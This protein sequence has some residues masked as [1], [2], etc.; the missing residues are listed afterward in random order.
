MSVVTPDT[1]EE[2]VAVDIHELLAEE[3]MEFI[4]GNVQELTLVTLE[5]HLKKICGIQ[6]H[7]ARAMGQMIVENG[8]LRDKL[9]GIKDYTSDLSQGLN[10]KNIWP[11]G[12]L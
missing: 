10:K 9:K 11:Q 4:D 2:H 8:S 7:T 3:V 6:Q 5:T 12:L 1:S